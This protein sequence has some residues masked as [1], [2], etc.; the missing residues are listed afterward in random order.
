MLEIYAS[1]LNLSDKFN[2]SL[3]SELMNFV[4]PS[5]QIKLRRFFRTEDKLRGL[6]ADLL[7]RHLIMQR[8]GLDHKDISFGTNEYGKPYLIDFDDFHF[9]I[10]HSGEW[11][12]VAIDDRPV[13]VDVEEIQDIDLDIAKNYFSDI[14]HRDLMAKKNPNDY[15]FTLW[16][17]KES[18]IKILGK[19]LSHPLNAFSIEFVNDN[20]IVIKENGHPIEDILFKQYDIDARYKMG[21]C[22]TKR[23][24]PNQV[25]MLSMDELC[26]FFVK[27]HTT[28]N[29]WYP[30]APEAYSYG[31]GTYNPERSSIL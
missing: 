1:H 28:K 5:K 13:G 20:E 31:N 23:A 29:Y 9:N 10:S 3:M 16:S 25:V 14:E 22:T 17:L 8:V 27:D 11:V 26:Q 15:F 2:P 12:V 21:V 19:G 18:Y 6:F 30:N 24:F 7:I 4:D